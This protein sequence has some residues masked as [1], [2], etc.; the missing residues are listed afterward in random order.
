MDRYQ[1]IGAHGEMISSDLHGAEEPI[2]W[3]MGWQRQDRVMTSPC[4]EKKKDILIKT[5]WQRFDL[6]GTSPCRWYDGFDGQ[7]ATRAGWTFPRGCGSVLGP[8]GTCGSLQEAQRGQRF[9]SWMLIMPRKGQ[10]LPQRG[11]TSPILALV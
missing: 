6:W 8:C 11:L 7:D 1:R 3:L 2:R 9:S 10:R 4:M 5:L